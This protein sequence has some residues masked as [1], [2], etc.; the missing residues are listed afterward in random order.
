MT[1]NLLSKNYQ[2][3]YS[4]LVH[5]S[6]LDRERLRP[7]PT[8]LVS[9]LVCSLRGIRPKGPKSWRHGFH[10]LNRA[11]DKKN[12][13]GGW[14]STRNIAWPWIVDSDYTSPTDSL[15]NSPFPAGHFQRRLRLVE[16]SRF[17]IC[18]AARDDVKRSCCWLTQEFPTSLV[19]C[20]DDVSFRELRG[21][22]I[23]SKYTRGAVKMHCAIAWLGFFI[24]VHGCWKNQ[25]DCILNASS[26]RNPSCSYRFLIVLPI[27]KINMYMESLRWNIT[28][29]CDVAKMVMLV[30]HFLTSP[31][32][33]VR[34]LRRT[35]V[36]C[37]RIQGEG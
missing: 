32:H 34:D 1:S 30:R 33:W 6:R 35:H 26:R 31:T 28:L 4:S 5:S 9:K 8:N 25:P 7:V 23:D 29:S 12:P 27:L 17:W 24:L 15:R 16:T 3:S 19:P 36:L 11:V 14:V 18:L 22:T 21:T 13:L 20:I 37:K 2:E 10:A